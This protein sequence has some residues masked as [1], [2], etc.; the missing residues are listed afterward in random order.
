MTER[1]QKAAVATL[2]TLWFS[3]FKK[4]FGTCS[5][6]PQGTPLGRTILGPAKNIKSISRDDLVHYIS[7]HYKVNAWMSE[8]LYFYTWSHRVRLRDDDIRHIFFNKCIFYAVYLLIP[9]NT[10]QPPSPPCPKVSR[11]PP[12]LPSILIYHLTIYQYTVP[13]PYPKYHFRF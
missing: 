5:L 11:S 9:P 1:T 6:Y 12:I 2:C 8:P 4:T 7:T 3:T 13:I 10:N